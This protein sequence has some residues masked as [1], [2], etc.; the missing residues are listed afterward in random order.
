MADEVDDIEDHVQA[1]GQIRRG[2]YFVRD[3]CGADLGLG[4]DDALG[5]RWR[6]GEKCVGNL[7]GRQAAY[8]AEGEGDLRL[9][10]QS[11]MAAGEDKPQPVVGHIVLIRH[12]GI[13]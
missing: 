12:R 9:R 3:P 10:R 7:L 1:P 13:S 6:L 4:A 5:H 2:G 8:G 11:G